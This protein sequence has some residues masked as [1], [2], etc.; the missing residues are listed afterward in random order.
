MTYLHTSAAV[1][2]YL[3]VRED[4]FLAMRTDRSNGIAANEIART[5]AGTYSQPVIVE[6]LSGIELCDDAR[7]ALRGAGL[8]HCA[9]VRSTGAGRAPRTVLLALTCEPAQLEAAERYSLPDRL[10]RALRNAGIG[11]RP[12]GTSAVAH[13]LYSGEEVRL[14]RAQSRPGD[15]PAERAVES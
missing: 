10:V 7:A 3:R 8:D 4:L 15:E 1:E 14:V 11:P 9:G 13:L 12:A 2:E 5:A 6:Y